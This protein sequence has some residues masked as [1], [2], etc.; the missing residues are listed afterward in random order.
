[1]DKN[2]RVIDADA[3]H[4]EPQYLWERYVEPDYRERIPRVIG[5]QRN[6]FV[7]APDDKYFP[8]GEQFLPPAFHDQWME[9]K[10]GEAYRKWWSPDIRLRDMDRHGWSIQVIL[11]TNANRIMEMSLK[12]AE[13]G[14]ALARAY[15][16]WCAEYASADPKRLKWTA[17]LPGADPVEMVAE[18]RRAVEK[19][20]AVSARN[21]LLPEGSVLHD[22]QYEPLWALASELDFPIS[23]HGESRHRRAAPFRKIRRDDEAA[24][25]LDHMIGFPMD[26]M[27]TMANFIFGGVLERYPKLRLGILESNVGWAL[28]WLPRMDD[29]SHGRRAVL[30]HGLR[31]KPS[32]YVLRQ[33]VISAD[34]DEPG[35][36][37]VIE[38]LGDE[39]IVWNT[40]YPHPDAPDPDKALSWFLDQ[41]IPE[42]SKKKILW[43]N[44]VRLYGPRLL[45]AA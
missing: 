40:D 9:D 38:F 28:F 12:D 17:T 14:A 4:H 45:E 44:A 41:P 3:H 10:Y 30:G 43:D 21:P 11:S 34:P 31:L 7:Y 13:M 1:M 25:A 5:M 39:N 6:F 2:Y 32:E 19:L 27:I 15:H 36:D 29:H 8:A 24:R 26:N 23:V 20:G 16:N 33:T 35:L 37:K 42:S 18:A 22:P